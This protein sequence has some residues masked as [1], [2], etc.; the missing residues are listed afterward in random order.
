VK[1]QI[2]IIDQDKCI[3]CGTCIQV[4][5]P[6]FNAITKLVNEAVPPPPPEDQRAVVRKTKEKEVA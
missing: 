1:G 2:H 6:R 3:K 4:C 5:P